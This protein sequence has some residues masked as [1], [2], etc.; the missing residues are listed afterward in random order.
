MRTLV[1]GPSLVASMEWHD[2]VASTQRLAA[3]AAAAGAPEGHLVLADAQHAGRGRRGREWHAP[4][5]TSLLA[6]LVLRPTVPPESL[7]LL[8]LVAAVALAEV[9]ERYCPRV[10]LKWP[11]DL[12]LGGR[13]AAGI[14]AET[15]A[16]GAVV[17][18]MGVNTD[19]QGVPRP[20]DAPDMTSLAEAGGTSVDRWRVLA[21]LMGVLGRRYL[22]WQDNPVGI[23]D[24]Y[25]RRCATLGVRVRV[26]VPARDPY[27]G[28]AEGVGQDGALEV[29]D[30]AGSLH[31]LTAGDVEHVRPAP[32]PP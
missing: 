24:P 23:L 28:V 14:L 21:A 12:L 29:R 18:G 9:A 31:R 11:N 16:G 3:D 15:A 13:K 20:V 6:S 10:A 1:E 25:R 4:A 19:W 7:P 32:P 22:D 5:G 2:E 27:V 30:N 26:T 17:L 8:S